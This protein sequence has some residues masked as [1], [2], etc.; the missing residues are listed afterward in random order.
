MQL[1]SKAARESDARQPGDDRPD[2]E[3]HH[4]EFLEGVD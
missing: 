3:D 4:V 1:A 2:I